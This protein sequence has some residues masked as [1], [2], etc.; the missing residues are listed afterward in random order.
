M[1]RTWGTRG[2]YV[3]PRLKT[4]ETDVRVVLG[5][6]GVKASK[7]G[8]EARLLHC[9]RGLRRRRD[10][11]GE[12]SAEEWRWAGEKNLRDALGGTSGEEQ[13]QKGRCRLSRDHDGMPAKKK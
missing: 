9:D 10:S 11:C 4:S 1:I 5:S 6:G 3:A 8:V 12:G 7:K 2:V 13:K